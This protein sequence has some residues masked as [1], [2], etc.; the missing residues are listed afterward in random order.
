VISVDLRSGYGETVISIDGKPA[1][2]LPAN[3]EPET[4]SFLY[5]VDGDGVLNV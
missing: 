3:Q 5:P 1:V 2:T 4:L